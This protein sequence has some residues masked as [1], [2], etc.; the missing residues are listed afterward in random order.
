MSSALPTPTG[1]T[2]G[3]ATNPTGPA[4]G[5]TGAATGPV[6]PGATPSAALHPG[7]DRAVGLAIGLAAAAA[8]AT[9]GPFVK[10]L[11]Q[12]GWT[13]GGAIVVRLLIGAAL[14]SVPTA[15]ALRGRFASVRANWRWILAFGLTGV[16]APST[17]YF[18]AVERLP[19]AVALLIEYTG[20]LLLIAWS[21]L[22]TRRMPAPGVLVGASLA[23]LGLVGVLDVTGAVALD[24]V[25]LVFAVC[26]A[27]GNAAYFALSARPL[28]IPPLAMAGLGMW[29][30]AVALVLLGLG[31][32]LPV[33]MVAGDVPMLGGEVPV[34]VPLLV[35]GVLPTAVAYGLSVISVR[36]LGERVA[37]FVA[38][39]EVLFAVVLAW[40]LLREAPTLVQWL[41]GAAVVAGVALVRR[42]AEVSPDDLPPAAAHAEPV[43]EAAGRTPDARVTASADRPSP[44]PRR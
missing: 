33:A 24:P 8:F 40:L 34:W 5:P 13:P 29:V 12:A 15:L 2:A 14:L 4:A 43:D 16:A 27:L 30:G 31:G 20:P 19:V 25:G 38:L 21:W 42:F 35:I 44:A 7:R 22:R 26:S 28:T 10:P 41:G 11:L 9:S 17:L 3:L 18:L 32:L 1:P 23:M 36:K 6:I 37:S 39:A